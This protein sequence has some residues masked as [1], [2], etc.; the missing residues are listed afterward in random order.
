M[1]CKTK[2]NTHTGLQPAK[3]A[4]ALKIKAIGLEN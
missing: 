1:F 4:N 2:T 3:S